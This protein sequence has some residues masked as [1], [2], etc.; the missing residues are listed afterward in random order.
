MVV[1][2]NGWPANDIN[3]TSSRPVPGS[4]RKLRVANGAAGDL[5]LWV[6]GQFDR[7]VE[8]ID[9]GQLDDW[10]YAERPV[11]G[12][13][14]LS[15]HASGTAVDLNAVQHI[16]GSAPLTSFSGPEVDK[17]H[18]ILARTRYNG[19]NLVRWGG[20]YTGR[21]DPMHFEINNGVTE[22]ECRALL[23]QLNNVE[24]EDMNADQDKRLKYVERMGIETQRRVNLARQEI[25]AVSAAVAADKDVDPKQL[26]QMIN[27]AVANNTPT[28]QENAAQ[29]LP[30]IEQAVRDAVPAD[31]ADAAIAKIG[32]T[33]T[34][35]APASAE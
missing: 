8:D 12:G 34:Q 14:D 23:A 15:N 10:G 27:K 25:A 4:S 18:A 17:I 33:L 3:R 5:L 22:A 24:D 13:T 19:R 29:V 6:A 32:A 30:L 20:D 21:R 35:L 1:S 11:R 28:A 31:V 7:L 26:E 16:L 2:Q 9:A